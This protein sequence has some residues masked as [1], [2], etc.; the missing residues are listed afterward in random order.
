LATLKTQ[1]SS[2]ESGKYEIDSK[3]IELVDK[4]GQG[5]S[6]VVWKGIWRGSTVAISKYYELTCVSRNEE[7]LSSLL[8]EKQ[9]ESFKA[10]A[11]LMADL[12]LVVSLVFSDTFTRPHVNVVQ[13]LGI[14]VSPEECMIVTEFMEKVGL[15]SGHLTRKRDLLIVFY[16]VELQWMSCYCANLCEGLLQ[17]CSIYTQKVRKGRSIVTVTAGIIHRDLAA[18]NIL[19]GN[20]A[21]FVYDASLRLLPTHKSRQVLQVSVFNPQQIADF[22]LSRVTASNVN[23]TRSNN[24]PIK[25]MSPEVILTLTAVDF[26]QSLSKRLYSKSSDGCY[27]CNSKL[28]Y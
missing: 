25:W 6:G 28:M 26:L 22:G 17:E 20:E 9:L 12:R 21:K 18:R 10:E 19:V 27:R 7:R 24:G 14:C 13:F 16:L 8:G 4:V 5:N 2:L 1:G 3:E 23:K 11:K 15:R